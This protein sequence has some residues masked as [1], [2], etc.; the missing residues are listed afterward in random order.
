MAR[1]LLSVG[2]SAF[3]LRAVFSSTDMQTPQFGHSLN[4][5]GWFGAID[6]EREV[7]R[8][9][10][11]KGAKMHCLLLSTFE[12]QREQIGHVTMLCRVAARVAQRPLFEA[13]V[14][15]EAIFTS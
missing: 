15:S 6:E 7:G 4:S 3:D 9:L 8:K 13:R 12:N 11:I 2:S 10:R 1:P 14:R 5:V